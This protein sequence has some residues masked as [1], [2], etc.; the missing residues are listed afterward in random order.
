MVWLVYANVSLIIANA[1][2]K[3]SPSFINSLSNSGIATTGCVS[4][5][6]TAYSLEKCSK[7]VLYLA[8]YLLN[9]SLSDADTKKYCC[10]R[11]SF[12]P[13]ASLSFGYNNEY[14]DSASFFSLKASQYSLSLNKSKSNSS[15]AS[16]CHKRNVL[17]VWLP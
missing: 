17:I 6:W 11:R 4:F 12:F 10:L 3:S 2:S 14:I 16:A 13:S 1:F 5:N 8:L 15:I 9:I 7:S